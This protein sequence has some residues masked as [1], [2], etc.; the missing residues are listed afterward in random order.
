MGLLEPLKLQIDTADSG[1][2]ALQLVSQKQ[3]H[4]IFMDHMMP[5][6]DGIETT[7]RI[8]AMDDEY[9]KNVPIIALTANAL[10]DAR[11]KFKAAGMD[12]FVA[13]PIEMSDICSKIKHW[14]P[15]ALIHHSCALQTG[16]GDQV[17]AVV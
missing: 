3:Y 16:T 15:R 11:E 17:K 7:E 14:L 6:M 8:R 1:K 5:V 2:R 4:I 12:D 10:M 13:K 9:Y